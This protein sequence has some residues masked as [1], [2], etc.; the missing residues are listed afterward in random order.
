MTKVS[1]DFKPMELD[2]NTKIA[3]EETGYFLYRGCC[4]GGIVFWMFIAFL[5]LAIVFG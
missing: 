1:T 2:E 4:C 5:I 3:V